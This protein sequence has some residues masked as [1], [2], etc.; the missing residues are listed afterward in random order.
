MSDYGYHWSR[1][2]STGGGI[3]GV[4]VVVAAVIAVEV[5]AHA[6]LW[7]IAG[8][9]AA[10]V[11]SV[12]AVVLL[13]RPL[14]RWEREAAAELERT[15]PARL[16]AIRETRQ[17]TPVAAQPAVESHYHVHLHGAAPQEVARVIR[18]IP[19]QH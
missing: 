9:A 6:I 3:A 5:I 12:A 15:R 11:V 17:V 1:C 10:V 19:D 14:R 18:A 4:A 13:T 16:A 8:T 2:S 7:L